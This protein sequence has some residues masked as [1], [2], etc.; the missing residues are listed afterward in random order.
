[1]ST[2]P[3]KTAN[4]LVVCLNLRVH[5]LHGGPRNHFDNAKICLLKFSS[6]DLENFAFSLLIRTCCPTLYLAFITRP[7]LCRFCNL[8]HIV[9]TSASVTF[10]GL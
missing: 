1:M 2:L 9:S 6:A 7:R 3:G 8:F 5:R 10:A 4:L